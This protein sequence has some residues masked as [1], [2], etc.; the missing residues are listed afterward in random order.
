VTLAGGIPSITA[1]SGGIVLPVARSIAELYDSHPGPTADRLGRFLMHAVY[2]GSAV[3]CAMFMTGQA[4]NVLAVT[5]AK[6]A[7]DVSITWAGWFMAAL[8]PGIA[9]AMVV[10]FL[11]YRLSPPT[12]TRTPAAAEFARVELEK[13]GPIRGRERIVLGVFVSVC[14]LWLTSQW[15]CMDVTVVALSGLAVLFLTN[16]LSW[17]TALTERPAWDIF[18]W[19]GGL[20]TLGDVLNR[21]GSPAALA[22]FVS[23]WVDGVPLWATLTAT[24]ILFFYVHYVFASITAHVLALFPPFVVMLIGI[25]VPPLL[26]VYS[27]ACTVNLAAGLTHYGTTTA[28]IVHAERYLD[29]GEWWRVGLF[30]SFANLAIWLTVGLAWWKF[31]GFW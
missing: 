29:V 1:R 21:T 18:V 9:S 12:L 19:Y 20:V 23:G 30:V 4:G 7:A 26:A 14:L 24:I 13:M 5:L 8:A 17:E 3:A 28:P 2:Q 27:L 31:L 16:I 10:P 15:H 11:V 22:S 6:Q 25:G